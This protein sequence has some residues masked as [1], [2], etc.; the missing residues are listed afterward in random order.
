[1]ADLRHLWFPLRSSARTPSLTCRGR[2]MQRSCHALRLAL[3]DALAK[4]DLQHHTS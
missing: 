3:T 4:K 1:V 2:S